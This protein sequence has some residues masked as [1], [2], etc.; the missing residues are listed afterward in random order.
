MNKS[1]AREQRERKL[2]IM[3]VTT[4]IWDKERESERKTTNLKSIRVCFYNSYFCHN[5]STESNLNHEFIAL[6]IRMHTA[7][8][9]L[10]IKLHVQWYIYT[11]PIWCWMAFGSWISLKLGAMPIQIFQN[12]QWKFVNLHLFGR[13]IREYITLGLFLKFGRVVL[14]FTSTF[15][16][17]HFTSTS[18]KC[19]IFRIFIRT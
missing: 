8:K 4:L 6:N 15:E 13:K 19:Q 2:T 1:K 12:S 11:H 5:T 16:I 18:F 10:W 7:W 3:T 9:Y 14:H 17:E